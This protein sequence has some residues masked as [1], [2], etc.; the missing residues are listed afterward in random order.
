MKLVEWK[1]HDHTRRGGEIIFT[2]QEVQYFLVEIFCVTNIYMRKWK[3]EVFS[4][5]T[6]TDIL[7]ELCRW[8]LCCP[9][10]R[11]STQISLSILPKFSFILLKLLKYE[12]LERKSGKT[13]SNSAQ[14]SLGFLIHSLS[15]SL[16]VH[17]RGWAGNGSR[18]YWPNGFTSLPLFEPLIPTLSSSAF[19]HEKLTNY[20]IQQGRMFWRMASSLN[21]ERPISVVYFTIFHIF[22]IPDQ[23]YSDHKHLRKITLHRTFVWIS[24]TVRLS[25][26][27]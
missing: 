12:M 22:R 9:A 16:S 25:V 26:W 20:L 27:I 24:L 3:W 13:P 1:K 17:T 14:F 7:F 8:K 2:L 18:Y 21:S 6:P 15:L 11:V 23:K 10:E 4:V 19:L 5:L